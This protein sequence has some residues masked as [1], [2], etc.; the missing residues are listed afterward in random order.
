MWIEKD[1]KKTLNLSHFQENRKSLFSSQEITK[2]WPLTAVGGA[3]LPS[4]QEPI[5]VMR[6]GWRRMVD[7]EDA[8]WRQQVT[9][10][11]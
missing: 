1:F 9:Y 5:G 7:V 6:Q 10:M 8:G 11:P 3:Q 4:A 2:P